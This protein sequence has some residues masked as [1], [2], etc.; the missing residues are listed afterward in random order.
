M[1]DS[2]EDDPQ[3]PG[4]GAQEDARVLIPAARVI[5]LKT[6]MRF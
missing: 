2:N 4:S 3:Y 1:P 6:G 5:P